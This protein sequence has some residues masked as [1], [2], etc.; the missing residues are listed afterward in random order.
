MANIHE[1][2]PEMEEG[3]GAWVKSRPERVRELIETRGFAPWKLYRMKSTGHRVVLHAFDEELSDKVT[4]KVKVLGRFNLVHFDRI[5]FGIDPGDLEECD[6][7]A[8]D[9]PLGAVL[10]NEE[11]GKA[12]E[13]VPPGEARMNAI[14][15]AAIKS[16]EDMKKSSRKA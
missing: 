16:V 3:W 14:R 1:V 11:V 15:K 9:E 4:L 13:G 12:I 7:P 10:T 2:T 6:L 5:V 8:E